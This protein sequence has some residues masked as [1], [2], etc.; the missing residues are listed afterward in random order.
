MT[1]QGAT[2]HLAR[3]TVADLPAELLSIGVAGHR[4]A[5][6]VP[7]VPG[8][9]RLSE[10]EVMAKT[11]ARFRGAAPRGTGRRGALTAAMPAQLER[12]YLSGKVAARLGWG[13]P[14]D[15]TRCMR[16]AAAHGVPKRMRGGMCQKLHIKATG[17]P[18]GRRGGRRR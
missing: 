10:G 7:Q 1:G 18:M 9:G 8:T 14:G 15:G 2:H 6:R 3:M 16:Q 12:S 5:G 17:T 11:R 13:S 4:E